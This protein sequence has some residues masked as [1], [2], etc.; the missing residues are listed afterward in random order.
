MLNASCLHVFPIVYFGCISFL[1]ND[2]I[3]LISYMS[4]G[5]RNILLSLYMYMYT[6]KVILCEMVKIAQLLK[7]LVRNESSLLLKLESLK[8]P[9][10]QL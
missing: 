3:F 8:L 5:V 7:E 1:Q 6:N 4:H 10:S 2:V 9:K